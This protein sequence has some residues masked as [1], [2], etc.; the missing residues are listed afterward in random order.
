MNINATLINLYNVCHRECWL[1]ANGINMEHTS[2][3][4]YDGKLLHELSYSQR[5]S[6]Y[7]EVQLSTTWKGIQL[8]GK[9][10]YYNNKTKTIHETKRSNKVEKAHE[11]Q[12]KFYIWL[13][14]LNKIENVS[15]KIEYPR[16][17]ETSKVFLTT[18]ERDY[19][20]S[21]IPKIKQLIKSEECPK[22]IN[23]K[24]CRSC[25]YYD[26]CYVGE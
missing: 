26:F 18:S 8:T 17:R 20:E 6:K 19:L 25:S 5:A 24:I 11:W 9:V 2:A 21:V 23:A 1:H 15:G 7:T 14:E 4:V 10:D 3:T 13:F 16:L 22:V 12:V